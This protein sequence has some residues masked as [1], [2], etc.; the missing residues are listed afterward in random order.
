MN[1]ARRGLEKEQPLAKD[2]NMMKRANKN[3]RTPGRMLALQRCHSQLEN[4][5]SRHEGT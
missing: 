4:V 1:V 2:D 3:L 5:S